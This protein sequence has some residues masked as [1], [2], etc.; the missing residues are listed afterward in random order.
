LNSK[1]KE[2]SCEA[3]LALSHIRLSKNSFF[4]V[5]TSI[6]SKDFHHLDAPMMADAVISQGIVHV[7]TLTGLKASTVKEKLQIALTT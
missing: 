4:H 3:F 7:T 1:I 6:I 2:S 5:I